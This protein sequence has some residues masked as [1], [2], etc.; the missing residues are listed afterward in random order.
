MFHVMRRASFVAWVVILLCLGPFAAGADQTDSLAGDWIGRLDLAAQPAFLRITVGGI[1]REGWAATIVLQPITAISPINAE[2]RPVLDSWR[3][4]RVS[5]DG[6]LW[7]VTAGRGP[8]A[9]RVDVRTSGSASTATVT[10]RDQ[11][12]QIALHHLTIVDRSRERERA[13]TYRLPSGERIHVWRPSSGGPIVGGLRRADGFLTYLEEATGRSGN[14]Y[15]VSGDTYV[16]GP[17]SVL[18]DPVRVRAVFRDGA[19]GT[20]R[21]IWQQ[22]GN[23]EVVGTLSTAYRREDLQL[24]GPGGA[25]GCD[26][27]IPAHGGKHPAAV[28]VPGAGA[29]D[30]YSVYMIAEAFAEHGVAALAC[31]KR[32]TGTSEGDW[33]LTSFEQQAQD[34]TASIR[35]LQQRSDIDPNRVGVWG[36]SEGAWVAPLTVAQNPRPAFLILAAVPA[37]SR[38]VSVLTGNVERLRREGASATEVAR[39]RQFFESYQQAIV[40]NDA[41]AIERL[42]HQYSGASWLPANMPTV[43]TLNEWS[44]RAR[45][46]WPHDPGPVLGRVTCPVL[47]IWGGEDQEF[48]PRVHKPL[49]EQSLRAARNSDFTLTV[50]PGADHSFGLVAASFVEQTGYAPEYLSTVLQWL[51]KRVGK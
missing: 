41:P 14:L 10:F 9:I 51:T 16:A 8:S 6:P 30:R 3:D 7:T 24:K 37:T 38:R 32:G 19:N 23:K 45:L 29:N 20:R 4:A 22:T 11:T 35:L 44:W 12:A 49:L 27:L 43:Q 33:R 31:D 26:L 50:V 39:Y 21:L 5:V 18:P 36:F 46:T 17:T 34:V 13:G 47:A 2:A 48:P 28:L 40:D 1:A 25:L 42:W 15:P